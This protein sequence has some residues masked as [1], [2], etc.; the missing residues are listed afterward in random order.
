MGSTEAHLFEQIA[1][2]IRIQ[3]AHGELQTGDR[4]PSIRDLARTWDCTPGTVNR[5]YSI[6]ADE[7]LV[8]SRRGSG[9]VVSANP[10]LDEQAPLRSAFLTN[11]IEN[12]LLNLLGRGYTESEIETS[13]SLA[14]DRWH[15]WQQT[16]VRESIP[17]PENRLRFVGS[18]DLAI[19]YLA[20]EV[21][22][23]NDYQ[24]S[25]SFRGSLGGLIALARGEGD[26]AGS[27]LW[28]KESNQYNIPYVQRVLPGERIALVTVAGR[29]FGL[30]LPPGNPQSVSSLL[31][32]TNPEVRWINRQ[33]G[34]GTRVWLDTQ[35]KQLDLDP[36]KIKGY[37]ESR[38]THN[39]IAE[40]ITNGE[41]TAGLGIQAAA[42]PYDLDF[43]PLA[44]E[45]YQLVIPEMVW[46]MAV[47]QHL[48]Q[49][50]QKEQ[51]KETIK[52]FGGYD[53]AE[54][55]KTIWIG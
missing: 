41:A 13:F 26:I 16:A 34:S 14:L 3:I 39:E 22:K 4:L 1:E 55:S 38:T 21:S 11:Q 35:L 8:I 5:A 30:M 40:A 36:A 19:E 46:E 47:C 12:L 24:L 37:N 44:Q 25:T 20:E 23:E 10:L 29:S 28:D 32:L 42:T 18:H 7:G 31:D 54:T 6:L 2:S 48:L 52:N 53:T 33:P 17:H 50:L 9:T 51:F 15:K 27:H 45:H 49:I 43:I